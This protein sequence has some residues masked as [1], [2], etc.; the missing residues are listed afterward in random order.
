MASLSASRAA[1]KDLSDG[2]LA[3]R[4][5]TRAALMMQYCWQRYLEARALE[6]DAICMHLHP[7]S[8]LATADTQRIRKG[9]ERKRTLAVAAEAQQQM[10]MVS[11]RQQ[12][13][14]THPA[15][16]PAPSPHRMSPTSRADTSTSVLYMFGPSKGVHRQKK[17]IQL[18]R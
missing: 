16:L 18:T 9:N 7:W 8:N 15:V 11:P 4:R 14:S 5:D 3:L 12:T 6:G 2:E 13:W 10:R 1:R 17:G